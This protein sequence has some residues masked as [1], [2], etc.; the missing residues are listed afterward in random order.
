MPFGLNSPR[1]RVPDR[2]PAGLKHLLKIRKKEPILRP[3]ATARINSINN[4]AG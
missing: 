2:L 4:I 3:V 1:F